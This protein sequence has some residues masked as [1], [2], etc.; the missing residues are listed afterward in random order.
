MNSSLPAHGIEPLEARIAPAAFIVTTTADSGPGSLRQAILDANALKGSDSITFSIPGTSI[1][2]P[3]THLPAITDTIF[4]NGNRISIDG[5]RTLGADGPN[6]GSGLMLLGSGGSTIRGLTIYGFDLA[7]IEIVDSSG[8]TIVSNYLGI[9]S[10]GVSTT[11]RMIDGVLLNGGV[12]NKIGGVQAGNTIGGN[13]I[14]IR[15]TGEAVATIVEGNA[16]GVSI[17]WDPKF[18]MA[19]HTGILVESAI[20][21][22][23]NGNSIGGNTG[24]GL[25]LEPDAVQ[26]E[27]TSNSIGANV[28]SN[29]AVPNLQWGIHINGARDTTVGAGHYASFNGQGNVIAGNGMGGI[30]LRPGS[31]FS[32]DRI[33]GNIIGTNKDDSILRIANLGP[34][35]YVEGELATVGRLSIANNCISGNEGAGIEVHALEGRFRT[36]ITGN[37]IGGSYFGKLPMGNET[38]I[39]LGGARGIYIGGPGSLG[40]TIIASKGDGILINN[41]SSIYVA[42]NNIGDTPSASSATNLGNKTNGVH[43]VNSTSIRVGNRDAGNLIVNNGGDGILIENSSSWC[44]LEIINN[45]IGT[46]GN[47]D[48]GNLGNGVH[49][50]DSASTAWIY[51]GSTSSIGYGADVRNIISGNDGAGI[52]VEKADLVNIGSNNIGTDVR[53]LAPIAN[54]GDGISLSEVKYAKVSGA[55]AGGVVAG[56]KGHGIYVSNSNITIDAFNIGVGADS[57]TLI[58]NGGSGIFFENVWDGAIGSEKGWNNVF[59]EGVALTMTNVSSV[60]VMNSKFRS[61]GA[62]AAVIGGYSGDIRLGF[63]GAGNMFSA[64]R[65]SALLIDQGYVIDIVDNQFFSESAGVVILAGYE[66]SLSRNQFFIGENGIFVD[67]GGDGVTPND[68]LDADTGPNTLLNSPLLVSAAVRGGQTLLRG[69]YRG[70]ANSDVRIEWY[71][72][73]EFLAEMDVHT[74][75][76]GVAKLKLDLDEEVAINAKISASAT[77][78]F[79]SSEFSPG[80]TTVAPPDVVAKGAAPGHNPRVQLRDAATGDILLNRLAF[81]KG[82]LAG[83]KVAVADVDHDGFTDL[84]ATARTGNSIVK[85]FSGLDGHEISKFRVGPI[86]EQA[87][88]SITAGD[89]DGDGSVEVVVGRGFAM[90][91]P[92]LVHDALTG[93][94]ESRHTPFGFDTPD[95]LNV[96]LEDTDGDSLPEIVIRAEILGG[97][98]RVTLD[99]LSGGIEKLAALIRM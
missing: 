57:T 84:I 54:S 66:N 3:L 10:S 17:G 68:P 97:L 89:L 94:F 37:L 46:D 19:N 90:G 58:T 24:C 38:G 95:R 51:V 15:I 2:A 96:R 42:G 45:F 35:I 5:T 72:N 48:R 70:A 86:N 30:W 44:L 29:Q 63:I 93:A 71:V 34:G 41:S 74:D 52:L 50:I 16:I 92:I 81:G 76:N 1:I 75:E 62:N 47:A 33:E 40:N 88:R 4:V 39:L 79:N 14:G 77:N 11:K 20:G 49:V 8:N 9:D 67:L 99:P 91:G 27:I 26:T 12:G 80:I 21:T 25:K 69:E 87:I 7:G 32:N 98:K 55:Y 43:I 73:G 23:I 83:V 60:D 78:E 36:E 85:V 13:E 31:V 64:D 56:N 65:N 22:I 59:S 53:G 6:N 61:S 82:F 28:S 18:P